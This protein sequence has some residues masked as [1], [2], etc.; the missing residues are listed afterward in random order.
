MDIIHRLDEW[1][2][3]IHE[4]FFFAQPFRFFSL[5]IQFKFMRRSSTTSCVIYRCQPAPKSFN[6]TQSKKKCKTLHKLKRRR[7]LKFMT[8]CYFFYMNNVGAVA[9]LKCE[10]VF[11]MSDFFFISRSMFEFEIFIFFSHVFINP[12]CWTY[13]LFSSISLLELFATSTFNLENF[14]FT[15]S[16]SVHSGSW[17][18][19][20]WS[21][22][23][24]F[25]EKIFH[26]DVAVSF[27]SLP[28]S[29]SHFVHEHD[30]G[31]LKCL[32]SL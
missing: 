24:W 8:E 28:F 11:P 32:I 25:P 14:G 23:M 21:L 27:K 20:I 3:R 7:R 1:R 19:S 9:V 30:D 16:T 17:V 18:L 12:L 13:F 5:F 10:S 29:P 2:F 4:L 15:S 26:H 22:F 6:E 31:M